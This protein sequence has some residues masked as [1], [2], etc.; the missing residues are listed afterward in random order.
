MSIARETQSNELFE[1]NPPPESHRGD[2]TWELVKEFPQQGDWT[3]E[4]Y[5]EREFEGLVEYD[6]GVLEFLPMPTWIHQF[7]VDFLHSNLKQFVQPR[8]LGFTAFAPLPVRVG[9]RHYRKPDVIYATQTRI[10]SFDKP[11]NGADLV[12]EVVSGSK[13]DRERDLIKKRS[14]YAEAEIPEYWIVDPELEKIS[15]LILCN[16]EYKVHG[17]FHSGETAT[18]VLLPGFE[19]VVKTCFD[20]GR[21]KDCIT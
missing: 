13:K 4:Q 2:W 18:S 15:V 5:L 3:E 14:I 12:M 20:A 16:G 17:E 11:S 7:I 19:I 10:Q 9:D 8:S 1:A 6:D 21:V